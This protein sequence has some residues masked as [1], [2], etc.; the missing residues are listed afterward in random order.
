MLILLATSLIVVMAAPSALA[1]DTRTPGYWKNH[2]EAWVIAPGAESPNGI[3]IGEDV[4]LEQALE[5]LKTP[6]KG[7]AR[8]N[9]QQKLIA[10][11]LSKATPG[12]WDDPDLFPGTP[13]L[14]Q[15]YIDAC[16]F[17]AAHPEPLKKPSADRNTALLMAS[18]IDHWLNY[19]D[20]D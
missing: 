8:I 18:Q 16:D 17:L 10:L 2:P 5:I 1:V 13:T 7:D 9:L 4:T 14:R 3:W 15:L 12:Y 19:Y 11:T 6:I 20:V